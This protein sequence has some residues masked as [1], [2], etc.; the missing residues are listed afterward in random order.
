MAK[1]IIIFLITVSI[2]MSAVIGF[3]AC[4]RPPE[5]AEVEERFKEL[6]E[7]SD[8]INTVL[9]GTG[10]PTDERIYDPRSNQKVYELIDE[11]GEKSYVYYYYAEDESY[12]RILWYQRFIDKK[13]VETYLQVLESEDTS[14]ELRYFNEE[15][16]WYYYDTD[17]TT[18]EVARY[19]TANDPDNYDYVSD[20]SPYLSIEEIKG[21]AEKVYSADY[22]ESIYETL[23]TGVSTSD[24]NVTLESLSARDIEYMDAQSAS[25]KA[26]LM[27]SNTYPAL[28]T[29]KRIYDFSTA[30]VVR[31]GSKK[32]VNIEVESYLEST[33]D[34]RETVRITMVLQDGEWYLDSGTY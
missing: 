2:L 6:V 10:L 25:T 18:P 7:A 21:A 3:S 28:V 22:L 12:G 30:E 31:P 16:G 34:K 33:P 4:S 26:Y 17:Y 8:E 19:Y 1:R 5:Y 27:Q 32:L 11:D 20:N 23:F 15:K 13:R 24:E 29:E 9:F 14:R